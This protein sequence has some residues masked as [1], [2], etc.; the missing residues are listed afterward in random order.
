MQQN[1][2]I[3]E[4]R[5]RREMEFYLKLRQL[6]MERRRE[7]RQH[8]LSVLQILSRQ[9]PVTAFPLSYQH[10]EGGMGICGVAVLMFFFYVVMR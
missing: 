7:E 4:E 9:A 10:D 8:E 6:E 2:K 1:L 5:Q 3:E